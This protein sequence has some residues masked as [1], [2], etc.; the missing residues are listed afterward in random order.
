[1]VSRT[2]PHT[3]WSRHASFSVMPESDRLSAK[4]AQCANPI[5]I[6]TKG[7]RPH[8]ARGCSL[9]RSNRPFSAGVN[10]DVQQSDAASFHSVTTS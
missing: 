6:A 1:M 3:F 5:W 2:D 10:Y 8:F 9:V 4:T 7:Y